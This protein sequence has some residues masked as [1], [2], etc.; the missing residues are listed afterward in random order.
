[1]ISIFSKVFES[2]IKDRLTK[3]LTENNLI[4][5]KQYGFMKKR[6]T[7]AAA[8]NLVDNIVNSLNKK[9]KTAALFIDVKK[10]FDSMD[11]NCLEAILFSYG[12]KDKALALILNFLSGREQSVRV[13]N[14]IGI[15]RK[16]LRGVPQGSIIGPLLF[17]IYINDLLRLKLIGS[18]QLFA[19][20]LACCYS[21]KSYSQL[22][23]DMLTDLKLIEAFLN[24]RSL[25]M[26]L[27][28]TK[29]LT[30]T[31][32]NSLSED[33]FDQLEFNGFLI[34]NV[35]TFD[36]LGLI[37]DSRL[38]WYSHIDKVLK[39]VA[40]MV[41]LLRRLKK[42][43]PKTLLWQFYFS[44][45]HS[46]LTYMLIVWGYANNQ[47]IMPLQRMQNKAIKY[48]LGRPLLTSTSL[49]YSDSLLPISKLHYYESIL[50]IYKVI[51]RLIDSDYQFTTNLSVTGRVTRQSNLFRPP[52]YVLGLAQ[53]S[54]F[55]SGVKLYNQFIQANPDS[56]SLNLTTLK[57]VLKRFVFVTNLRLQ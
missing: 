56:S 32:R 16:V 31:T 12:I 52:N 25:S 20:D 17:I 4:C 18:P 2:I 46:H 36:Y 54:I 14:V 44:H 10:A 50:F 28:K 22:K 7:S 34:N 9:F 51:H 19:D 57:S 35:S 13:G 3:H 39:K 40:P 21:A 47:R 6:C 38:N 29:F 43:L 11:F 27:S 42:F 24:S 26:N 53:N 48:V 30:F 33:F 55:Y 49:L 41:G 15:R 1:V 23:K 5:S 8:S 45:I 37:L